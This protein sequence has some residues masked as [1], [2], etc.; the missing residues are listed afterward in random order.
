[1][2]WVQVSRA[3]KRLH[4]SVPRPSSAKHQLGDVRTWLPDTLRAHLREHIATMKPLGFNAHALGCL[5]SRSLRLLLGSPQALEAHYSMLRDVFGPC[6]DDLATSLRATNIKSDCLPAVA[7]DAV[8]AAAAD[9][10]LAISCLHKAMLSGP[11]S[12]LAFTRDSLEAHLQTLVDVGLFASGVDA[13]RAACCG[14]LPSSQPHAEVACETQG[15]GAGG[16]R[17]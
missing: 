11:Y 3:L 8:Y 12:I 16:G 1:M 14:R 13:R 2:P 10:T 5:A 6:A 17:Q 15:G 4:Q 9:S 7:H